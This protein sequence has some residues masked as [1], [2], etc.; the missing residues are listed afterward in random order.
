MTL[1]EELQA[2]ILA[3]AESWSG[4][5]P[6]AART[7]TARSSQADGPALSAMNTA[8][9]SRASGPDLSI[10]VPKVSFRPKQSDCC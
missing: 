10:K 8:P 5:G 9:D 3:K 2:K 1:L 7:A 6:L 4:S